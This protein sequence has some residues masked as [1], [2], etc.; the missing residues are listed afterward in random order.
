MDKV[1]PR[2]KDF[3]IALGFAI[4]ELETIELGCL[5]DPRQCILKLFGEWAISKPSY[6]WQG[7]IEALRD[8]GLDNL[9]AEVEKFLSK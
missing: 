4:E 3:G 9:A 5:R 6:S 1:T 8:S 2:W 7:M